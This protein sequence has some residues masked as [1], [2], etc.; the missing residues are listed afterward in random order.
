MHEVYAFFMLLGK[1]RAQNK[2]T[3]IKHRFVATRTIKI[4]NM[5][6]KSS[7]L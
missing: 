7:L 2:Q 1:H 4:K 3:I 6:L 5:Y